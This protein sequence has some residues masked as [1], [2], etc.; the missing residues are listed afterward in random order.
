MANIIPEEAIY[1]GPP[2]KW[3]IRLIQSLTAK[4]DDDRLYF[5]YHGQWRRLK[6]DKDYK[7]LNDILS[8]MKELRM[9]TQR[10]EQL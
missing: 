7:D 3:T 9:E 1:T 2:D 6:T 8:A 4:D 10:R 5:L